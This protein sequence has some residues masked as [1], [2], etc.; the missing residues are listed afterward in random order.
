[1]V[2]GAVD[3]SCMPVAGTAL[4]SAGNGEVLMASV[5]SERTR[6]RKPGIERFED[7]QNSEWGADSV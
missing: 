2:P 3:S 4:F 6:S 1:M 7:A 5:E